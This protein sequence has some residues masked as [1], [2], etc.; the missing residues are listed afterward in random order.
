MN[1]P[2][3]EKRILSD[4]MKE[5]LA[6]ID[7]EYPHGPGLDG[8]ATIAQKKIFEEFNNRLT[9]LKERYETTPMPVAAARTFNPA[10]QRQEA[11][12]Q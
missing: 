11:V 8:S 12:A 3:Y 1:I 5:E 7:E 4:W 10:R 9:T 2:E 6:R